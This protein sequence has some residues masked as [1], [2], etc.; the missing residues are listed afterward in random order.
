MTKEVMLTI[1]DLGDLVA[2][3]GLVSKVFLR[4]ID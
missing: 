2:H 3:C 4:L 1:N